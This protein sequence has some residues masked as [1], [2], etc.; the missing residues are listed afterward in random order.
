MIDLR[1]QLILI[2]NLLHRYCLI[3]TLCMMVTTMPMMMIICLSSSALKNRCSPRCPRCHH[4]SRT[5]MMSSKFFLNIFIGNLHFLW[6]LSAP[7]VD[8]KKVESRRN[9][10]AQNR[11][12]SYLVQWSSM[13]KEVQFN[14]LV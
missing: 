14:E 7:V 4:N 5:T 6:L 11:R 2:S 13:T 8:I 1:F 10:L 3:P 12:S 9:D